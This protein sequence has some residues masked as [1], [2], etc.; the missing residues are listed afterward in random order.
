MGDSGREGFRIDFGGGAVC[1][2]ISITHYGSPWERTD[3][4]SRRST[5]VSAS[6]SPPG[7]SDLLRV[8][9][10]GFSLFAS[11]PSVDFVVLCGTT[12]M[13]LRDRLVIFLVG[14]DA[15]GDGMANFVCLL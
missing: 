3:S 9:L 14:F 15:S 5:V 11:S 10:D 12:A 4:L 8:L 2:M 13:D 6:C 1:Q 7:P